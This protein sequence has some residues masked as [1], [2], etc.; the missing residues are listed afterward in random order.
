MHTLL[1]ILL[2]FNTI[3]SGCYS[4]FICNRIWHLLKKW[5]FYPAHH[6]IQIF[7]VKALPAMHFLTYLQLTVTNSSLVSL[8]ITACLCND[9]W[10]CIQTGT[11]F[12][13]NGMRSRLHPDNLLLQ[14]S[15]LLWLDVNMDGDQSLWLAPNPGMHPPQ[16]V[17]K[18]PRCF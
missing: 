7:Q 3:R 5:W 14:N 16:L 8:T 1:K 4:T 9:L 18:P 13:H 15:R 17:P 2:V 10:L 12:I 11:N 6:Q